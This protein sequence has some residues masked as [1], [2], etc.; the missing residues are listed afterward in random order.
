MFEVKK[1]AHNIRETVARANAPLTSA[2]QA[3]LGADTAAQQ[4]SL[5]NAGRKNLIINGEFKV[6]CR[7][8]WSATVPSGT[9]NVY[10]ADRWLS[11]GNATE[12]SVTIQNVTLP[13]GIRTKSHKTVMND[14]GGSWVH[15]Y[16]AIETLGCE[17]MANQ[18]VTL[19]CWVRTN[20]RGQ[21][22]RICDTL[23]CYALGDYIPPDSEWHYIHATHKMPRVDQ[24]QAGGTDYLQFHP[25]FGG[26]TGGF[27]SGDFV[28]FALPQLE[29]GSV[30]TPF[31]HRTLAEE[32]SLCQRY[33]I[34][35]GAH[36][37]DNTAHYN[38]IG[39]GWWRNTTQ[40]YAVQIQVN[41]PTTLRHA[42]VTGTVDGTNTFYCQGGTVSTTVSF[43]TVNNN[44]S[45]PHT[46][47][48]DFEPAAASGTAPC[49]ACM[50]GS[51]NAISEANAII[52]DAEMI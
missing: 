40:A 29:L 19:S 34:R 28:E 22:L 44:G 47:W 21:K 27:V 39:N 7:N 20:M 41:L 10:T 6:N 8:K 15:P 14:D 52:V 9:N 32:T 31:E 43:H 48:I 1:D 23:T 4:F 51:G 5:I 12:T 11:Y 17:W 36:P 3:L 37:D 49:I 42:D 30:P 13:N 46:L 38:S 18:T 50:V 2:G 33:A 25:A 45:S 26:Y 24:F 16:Q 35:L